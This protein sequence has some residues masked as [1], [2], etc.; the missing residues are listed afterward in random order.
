MPFDLLRRQLDVAG[1]VRLE[2]FIPPPLLARL[3][4]Q[5]EAVFAAEG[6]DAGAEFKQE[7]D[8]RR[9]ANLVDKGTVFRESIAHPLL[10]PWIEQVLGPRFKL[11]SLNVRSV[12]ARCPTTQPL[13]CDMAAI[14]DDRG[15]WVC[16]TVWMIDDFTP[17]NGPLRVV[18]GS[19][20]WGRLPQAALADPTL[21]HPDEVII[22]GKAGDV[23]VMNAHVWHGGMPNNTD[24]PRTAMHAFYCRSDKPQQ[25]HQKRLLRPQTLDRLTL[26][27]RL[28]LAIDDPLNDELSSGAIVRSGF[29]K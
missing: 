17:E 1:Y 2:G 27:Q 28:I 18:P 21:K 6:T 14:A 15:Y 23:V 13:H 3:R 8:C 9:L 11:S 26:V 5:I 16:N 7:S 20:R 24:R 4:E 29:M 12:N 10:L 22:T 25:Q 19:H